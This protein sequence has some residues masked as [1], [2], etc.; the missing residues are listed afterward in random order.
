M[1]KLAFS[2]P[3]KLLRKTSATLIHSHPQFRGL[4]PLFLGHAPASIAERHYVAT[5]KSALDEALVWL[6]S[7]YR[8][9]ESF[10]S[11]PME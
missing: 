6:R 2:K 9:M 4:D 7:E 5:S 11:I 3:F 10:Q 1:A 8:V